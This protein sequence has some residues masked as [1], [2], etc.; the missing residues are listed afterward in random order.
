[1]HGNHRMKNILIDTNIALDFLLYRFGYKTSSEIVS[2]IK[3][4]ILTGWFSA[5]SIDTLHYVLRKKYGREETKELLKQFLNGFVIL[6]TRNSSI[7]FNSSIIDFEDSIVE[8]GAHQFKL[9]AIVTRNK[10]DFENSRVPAFTPE[11][12]LE[13][14]SPE[15]Q[16]STASNLKVPFLDLKAQFKDIYN[17]VDDEITNVISNTSFVLGKSVTEFEKNFAEAHNVKHCVGVSS[18]TDGNHMV[19]WSLGIGPG[20]EVIIPA[21]TFIATAW[22]ATLCG[23][24]PVFVDCEQDSYNIDP[25]KVEAAITHQYKS[26]SSSSFVWSAC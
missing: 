26:Y 23:A 7:D 1:M 17:E 25:K 15:S 5:H 8:N 16:H 19:L 22:G 13:S 9:D 12:F 14:I 20:D 11:E 21:N 18:G 24:K 2:L 4:E 6:P 10:K 3:D